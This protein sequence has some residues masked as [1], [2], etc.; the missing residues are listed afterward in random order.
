MCKDNRFFTFSELTHT[1]C[2]LPNLP[3]K[4][5]HVEN[6]CCLADLLNEIRHEYAHPIIVNSAFRTPA[7]NSRVGGSSRSLH[8]QGRAAD[9]RPNYYP[10]QDYQ[11]NLQSLIDVVT[12]IQDR[13]TEFIIYPTFI[14]IAL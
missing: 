4:M 12:S 10:S 7:V 5:E 11:V 9:I 6:L 2:D 8:L 14:H 1:D 3:T 13:L